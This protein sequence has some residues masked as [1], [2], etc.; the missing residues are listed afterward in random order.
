MVAQRSTA[1]NSLFLTDLV[2]SPRG[3]EHSNTISLDNDGIVE[4]IRNLF[5]W[6]VLRSFVVGWSSSGRGLGFQVD[7]FMP[8]DW[9]F[10]FR[11][12]DNPVQGGVRA[13]S[14]LTDLALRD[15]APDPARSWAVTV[16]VPLRCPHLDGLS[17]QAES[18]ALYAIEDDL[19]TRLTTDLRGRYVG[20]I[21]SGGQ[22]VHCYYLPSGTRAA[23]L[24]AE[25]IARHL[26]YSA[27]TIVRHDP[28]WDRYRD[29]LAP[30]PLEYQSVQTRRVIESARESGD[31]LNL[32]RPIHH[33]VDFPSTETR[34]QFLAQV[35]GHGFEIDASPLDDA[36]LPDLPYAAK[37][38]RN[39]SL[40]LEFL[41]GLVSDLLIRA[42]ESG[43]NYRGW[44]AEGT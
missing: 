8:Q 39:D 13:A 1:V 18:D 21:T 20:R 23:E 14:I 5:V 42:E 28:H 25:V 26:D 44:A 22:R 30:T 35:R 19:F 38:T 15:R 29:E 43:G 2:S 33:W 31:E 37:L 6:N 3:Y 40:Q 24:V 27:A 36:H 10:F 4:L 34:D 9:D 11:T 41:D 32:P 17:D 16:A 12:V 7:S